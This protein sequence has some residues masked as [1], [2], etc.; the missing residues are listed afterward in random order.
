M[1]K[2]LNLILAIGLIALTACSAPAAIIRPES[3]SLPIQQSDKPREGAPSVAGGDLKTLVAG[4]SVFAVNLYQTLRPNPGN[5]FFSPYSISLALAMTY[6]GARGQT[7]AQ[8]AEALQFKLAQ[9][10]LHPAF[11]ALDQ[12]LARRAELSGVED[13]PQTGFRLN[14]ANTL[15]GQEGYVFLPEFLD[16][17]SENYGAGLRLLDFVENPDASRLTINDW[18]AQQTEQKIKDLLQPGSLNR[19][20]R[21]VLTNAIYF[22]APWRSSFEKAATRPDS[23]FVLDGSTV[24]V[25]M[26]NQTKS[27]GYAAAKDYQA[28]ELPYL[29]DE[30]SMLILLPDAGHFQSFEQSLSADRLEIITRSLRTAELSLTMPRF[31]FES[32]FSLPETLKTM[33]MTD[34]FS[35]HSA[36]FSAMDGSGSLYISDVIHKAFIDVHEE[37]TE[38]AAATAVIMELRSALPSKPLVVRIDRPFIVLIRDR[39]TGAILFLGR[40]T[41]PQS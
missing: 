2:I 29:G 20:T 33:G 35:P 31:T 38:A 6:A 4:N 21:L 8:M 32:G 10:Q 22:N 12:E 30:V 37:G 9:A 13:K 23:F 40:V 25:P 14:I 26:M 36:D 7:E 15:W 18:V 17:L 41:N 27:F 5:L 39:G 19:D 16:L 28:V 11:N 1:R 3:E 24:T 34:A